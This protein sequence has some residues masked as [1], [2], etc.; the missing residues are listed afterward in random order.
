MFRIVNKNIIFK[1][2]A[3]LTFLSIYGISN[4]LANK[5]C[6]YSGLRKILN[7]KN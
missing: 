6:V 1:K 5:L 4:S 2:T 7:L 3:Y